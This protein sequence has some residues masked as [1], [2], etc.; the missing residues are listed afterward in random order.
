M[1]KKITDLLREQ[2]EQQKVP[3]EFWPHHGSLSKDL[4]EDVEDFLRSDRPSN[5]VCTTTL[6]MGIDVGDVKSIA[7][8]GAPFS[9]ASMRQR[10]GRSGRRAGGTYRR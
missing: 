3:N 9:V 7:Q 1:S 5:V 2:S 6:E 10:I 4:R 8:V